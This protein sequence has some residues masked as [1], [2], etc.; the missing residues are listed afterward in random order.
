MCN[1]HYTKRGQWFNRHAKIIAAAS[2][3][4]NNREPGNCRFSDC[5]FPTPFPCPVGLK[6]SIDGRAI[7]DV[8]QL[9]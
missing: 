7:A 2:E 1:E 8:K 4:T 5:L 3:K 9:F 6:A